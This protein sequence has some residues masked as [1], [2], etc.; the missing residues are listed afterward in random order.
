MNYWWVNQK[1]TFKQESAGGYMWSPKKNK[2]G[3]YVQYY[4]NMCNVFPGDIVFSYRNQQIAALGVIQCPGY[5]APKPSEFGRAGDAWSVDGWRVD[6]EYQ[7]LNNQISPKQHM[8]ELAPL[9]PEKYSPIQANGD[10]NQVYL[11]AIS[12]EM[13]EKLLELINEEPPA[14]ETSQ[15]DIL[16]DNFLEGQL[17]GEVTDDEERETE[18]VQEVKSRKGQGLFRSRLEMVEGACRVTGAKQHLIASHIKPWSKSNSIERLDGNNG[19]LLSPHVDLLFDKGYISFED[20]GNMIISQ[21]AD[22]E[23]LRLW[24]IAA[25]NV[26]EFNDEQKVYLQYHRDQVFSSNS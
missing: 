9:L 3:G 10:G 7:I 19:L 12:T 8:E 17:S 25:K 22:R 14:V 26:G 18:I 6:V 4:E 5:S 23:T 16:I 13:G 1:Q 24:G 15:T 11:C 20:D 21:S 2:N